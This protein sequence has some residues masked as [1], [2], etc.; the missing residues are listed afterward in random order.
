MKPQQPMKPQQEQA[1]QDLHKDEIH[2]THMVVV[3]NC[4]LVGITAH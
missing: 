4:C 3:A 2:G 1:R